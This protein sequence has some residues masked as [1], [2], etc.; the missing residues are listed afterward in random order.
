GEVDLPKAPDDATI[1]LVSFS[2][3]T[4]KTS[5]QLRGIE[6]ADQPRKKQGTIAGAAE[7]AEKQE[8]AKKRKRTGLFA[9]ILAGLAG[10]AAADYAY[11]NVELTVRGFMTVPA[12]ERQEAI[13]RGQASSKSMMLTSD[14]GHWYRAATAAEK[15]IGIAPK[16]PEPRA[17]AAQA[18]LAASIDEGR[19]PKDERDKAG[20]Y[21][22]ELLKHGG[23]GPQIGKAPPVR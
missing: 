18:Y 13:T 19:H 17:L 3:P 8:K 16:L 11:F 10:G 12:R 5:Q 1:G 9:A 21:I 22:P 6:L 4:G 15:V 7:S 14:A 2:V 23:T 20:G